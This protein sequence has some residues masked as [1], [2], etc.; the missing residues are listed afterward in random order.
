M[1]SLF[2]ISLFVF[3][4]IGCQSNDDNKFFQGKIK[5]NGTYIKIPSFFQGK[6]AFQSDQDGDNE[7]YLLDKNGIKKL[8]NNN[9]QDEYPILSE[10]GEKIIFQ[11]NPKGNKD[12]DIFIMNKDGKSL[13]PILNSEDWEGEGSFCNNEN[14][15]IV[16]TKNQSEIYLYNIKNKENIA[17]LEASRWRSIVPICSPSYDYIIFTRKRLLGWDIALIKKNE[18]QIKFITEGGKNCRG[19]WSHKGNKI[20]FVST[21]YDKKGDIWI[22]NTDGSNQERMTYEDTGDYYPAWSPDDKY[23]VYSSSTSGKN[24]F[25]L[26]IIELKSKRKWL[27]YDS[28][29]DERFPSWSK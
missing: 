14:S 27:I 5:K 17:L 26:W 9:Y 22:M 20:A 21:R 18:E 10:D 24:N 13:M 2:L 6:I 29:G 11:A 19:R 23:I 8:T 25:A 28:A 15:E 12:Y 3:F 1:R 7:I 4:I 16:Y